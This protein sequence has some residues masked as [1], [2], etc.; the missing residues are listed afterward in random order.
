MTLSAILK[1]TENES[2]LREERMSLK[3][4][5]HKV[6][7]KLGTP[8]RGFHRSLAEGPFKLI[9]EVKRKS[10]SM[11]EINP[12]AE[13]VAVPVYHTHPF[14]GAISV[15]TQS[16]HFG[17]STT[18]LEAIHRDTARPPKPILRKDFITSEY[19]VYYSRLIGADA[20]LLMANV[21]TDPAKFKF[22]H[23]LARSLGMDVLCEVHEESELSVLPDTASIVGINAR[24]FRHTR[25]T[26]SILQKILRTIGTSKFRSD[27]KTDIKAFDLFNKLPARCLKVAESGIS[28]ENFGTII[29]KYGFNAGLVGTSLLSNERLK[30]SGKE[31]QR[32]IKEQIDRLQ[33]IYSEVRGMPVAIPQGGNAAST[34]Q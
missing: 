2:D 21:V 9:A 15:L 27:T 12:I 13:Q 19:E 24:S 8:T 6:G 10:P 1:A 22:L 16:T 3:I 28:T 14:V 33:T 23:D 29:G 18:I 34:D 7:K 30:R 32:L 4:L 11:G 20:I 26:Q 25:Q 17:G 5:K 31:S